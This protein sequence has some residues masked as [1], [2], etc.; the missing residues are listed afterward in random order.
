M[1]EHLNE[2]ITEIVKIQ[3]RD[4]EQWSMFKYT[5]R[6][7]KGNYPVF[8]RKKENAF[9]VWENISYQEL[10]WGKF[11]QIFPTNKNKKEWVES[12]FLTNAFH[13]AF[14]RYPSDLDYWCC[15]A[16]AKKLCADMIEHYNSLF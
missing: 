4:W 3:P 11:K 14:K 6:T 12:F 9:K 1:T 15:L 16:L 7:G 13:I 5:L 2:K 10:W 8:Y